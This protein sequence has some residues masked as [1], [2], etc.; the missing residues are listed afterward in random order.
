LME[1]QEALLR[2]AEILADVAP[3]D[4]LKRFCEKLSGWIESAVCEISA[5]RPPSPPSDAQE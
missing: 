4:P 2:A 5:N 1:G 3:E